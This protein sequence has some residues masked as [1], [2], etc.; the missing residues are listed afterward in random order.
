MHFR[1]FISPFPLAAPTFELLLRPAKRS[2]LPNPA[3]D[4]TGAWSP[5][6]MSIYK[7]EFL[8][9]LHARGFIHQISDAAGLDALGKRYSG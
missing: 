2:R 7:S 9:V 6:A 8:N 1:A 5:T 3:D 4:S